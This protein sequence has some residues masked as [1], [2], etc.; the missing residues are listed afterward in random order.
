MLLDTFVARYNDVGTSTDDGTGDM[1]MGKGIHSLLG[2][3]G[4]FADEMR[5]KRALIFLIQ[6]II[7]VTL[8]FTQLGFAGV[9]NPDGRYF[10]LILLLVP[11]A[12]VPLLLGT[13]AGTMFGFIAGCT[14]L[15]HS[16]IMPLSY[17]EYVLVTPVTSIGLLTLCG[18]VQGILYAWL[19]PKHSSLIRQTLLV[20]I[21]CVVVS[22]LCSLGFALYDSRLQS[23]GALAGFSDEV[24]TVIQTVFGLTD[25]PMA[26]LELL[27]VT[28][29]AWVDAAFMVIASEGFYYFFTKLKDLQEGIGLRLL[30]GIWL[31]NAIATV[32]MIVTI[33][34]FVSISVRLLQNAESNMRDEID[35]L[36]TQIDLVNE[37]VDTFATFVDSIDAG[38]DDLDAQQTKALALLSAPYDDLLQGY[39]TSSSGIVIVLV[40]GRV[41]MSGSDAFPLG[42]K[43]DS[44]VDAD[45]RDAIA[46]SARTGEMQR[47]FFAGTT[48]G[49]NVADGGETRVM[50]MSY[51]CAADKDDCMIV[52]IRPSTLVFAER[53]RL[54][55]EIFVGIIIT[56][57]SVY[58]LVFR[59]LG[60]IVSDRINKTNEVLGR[61]TAGDL[62]ARM[63]VAG[64]REF[65]RLSADINTTVDALNGWIEEANTRMDSELA[66]ARAIQESA[67]PSKFPPFPHIPQFD[68]YAS[69]SPAKEVGGDFYDFFLIGS[70]DEEGGKL[71][72]MI[73]DVSDKGVP[74]A[75]FMMKAKALIQD[76]MERG[77]PL[78]EAVMHANVQ[79]CEG[80]SS[81]SFVTAWIGV[82][83]YGVHHVEYVNAGHNPPLILRHD[84]GTWE[85]LTETSGPPL[86]LA[87]MPYPSASF[88]C[89][90]GDTLFLYTDGVTEAQNTDLELYGEN[91]LEAFL[92]E[93]R[94]PRADELVKA[95][96]EDVA[97]FVEGAEQSDDLT[98]LAL[99]VC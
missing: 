38:G 69:M 93:V 7:S 65:R 32:A 92:Q 71:G 80:N 96:G 91:R 88:S 29:Q 1:N 55:C 54:M 16:S 67:L 4:L 63:E 97:R 3:R 10:Y 8:T 15:A 17:Y 53:F 2:W 26:S 5:R 20:G 64:A 43:L 78:E 42:A 58:A 98:M 51:V 77:L 28:T 33:G 23:E 46:R 75:L 30:F 52:M 40:D 39:P 82:L 84:L 99:R 89:S 37:R 60:L 27:S 62:D 45:V 70:C 14:L 41:F 25:S 72:F 85:W 31:F 24:V 68:V 95:V 19:L 13:L 49:S 12:I 90:V 81:C 74:A 47:F 83:D 73:A 86:G 22:W 56:A 11:I 35:F 66:A 18:F 6:V 50:R 9:G 87:E 44:L 57:V 36:S 59:M 79:L 34:S 61:I 48:G 76:S 21:A 94:E